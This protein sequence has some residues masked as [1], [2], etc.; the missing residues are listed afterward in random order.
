MSATIPTEMLV[1][2]VYSLLS[3]GEPASA[4]WSSLSGRVY[5][6]IIPSWSPRPAVVFRVV[7]LRKRS[8]FRG[9]PDVEGQMQ[10][11]V[12]GL[13]EANLDDLLAIENAVLARLD[14]RVVKGVD[15]SRFSCW[16]TSRGVVN[17]DVQS[18]SLRS[19]WQLRLSGSR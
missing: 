9:R 4:A 10:I 8:Y 1:D 18:L 5:H 11:D 6:L 7:K 12:A 13:P 19:T 17:A 2:S 3:A 14:D 16:S 15:G